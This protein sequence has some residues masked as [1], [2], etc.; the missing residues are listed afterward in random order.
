[1]KGLYRFIGSRRF[2][3]PIVIAPF[4]YLAWVYAT[5][6]NPPEEPA[7]EPPAQAPDAPEQPPDPLADLGFDPSIFTISDEEH[8]A[9]TEEVDKNAAPEP[10][11][12]YL[13][14]K[15]TDDTGNIAVAFFLWV[16][17]LT[18]LK[19]LFRRNKL[20]SALNRHRRTIGITCFFYATLHLA[21]YLTN[22][23][24]TLLDELTRF[25]IAAG[26]AAFGILLIL[27]VTSTN[28]AQRKMGGRNWKKLHR[29]VYL[30]IPLLIY[31]K[32]WAGKEDW[33]KIREAFVWFSPLLVLQT[34]RI[35]KQVRRKPKAK[36]G[37]PS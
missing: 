18:P 1:M 23:L 37:K 33:G 5:N 3:L 26:L 14:E 4:V 21:I 19:V 10:T 7:P 24:Q 32:G 2:I 11:V 35:A 28:L 8:E 27:A 36:A 9:A 13:H 15:I 25:Y 6:Q 12:T 17:C 20:L 31:H 22:G 34:M 16:L 30:A 29:I